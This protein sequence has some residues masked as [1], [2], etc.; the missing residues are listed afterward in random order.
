[1]ILGSPQP[2]ATGLATRITDDRAAVASPV[3]IRRVRQRRAIGAAGVIAIAIVNLVGALLPRTTLELSQ[4]DA[5]VGL[6]ESFAS[7]AALAMLG[8]LAVLA[9][10]GVRAG[11][12]STWALAVIVGSTSAVLQL[13]RDGTVASAA[14]CVIGVGWLLMDRSFY[15]VPAAFRWRRMA[16]PTIVAVATIVAAGFLED[17][18]GL[19]ELSLGGWAA[20]LVRGVLFLPTHVQASSGAATAYLDSLRIV[21]ALMWVSLIAVVVGFARPDRSHRRTRGESLHHVSEYGRY[22]SVPLAALPGNDLLQIDDTT[23]VG[24]RLALGAFVAV[25][26]PVSST[27][28]EAAAI[29]AFIVAC[30]RWGVVPAIL[31]A[32]PPTALAAQRLGFTTLR[33]GEEAFIDLADFSLAG[34]RR[35]NVRHSATRAR[36]DDISIVHYTPE[37]RTDHVD[38]DLH[39]LSNEW[40][41][42]K[43]GPELGFTLGH[44]DLDRLGDHE[45]FV[46]LD[47]GGSAVAFVT[48]LRYDRSRG[49]L[50]DLMRRDDASPP[51][52]MELLISDSLLALRDRGYVT[53]SLGGV[54]LASTADRDGV[55]QRAMAWLYEHG[56]AVYEAKSLFAFKRKFDPRWE[57]MYLAYPSGADLP[58]VFAAIGR[59]FLPPVPWWRRS[60]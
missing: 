27:G 34:K 20:L 4:I 19:P 13:L 1:M 12:R 9:A 16:T 57:P 7:R 8:C 36:R 58:R 48:W 32:A 59:A 30:E 6:T 33:I 38:R 40:L 15:R 26:G 23:V 11:N 24:G 5:S 2:V 21:G 53:A 51:G 37:L 29:A 31:D 28:D 54:P 39:R 55:V 50:L 47:P 49:A 14:V 56:G 35:A 10:R 17:L 45:L 3:S 41:S 46:A 52:I 43:R 18:N 22:S 44:L 25:G 42:H 60:Q